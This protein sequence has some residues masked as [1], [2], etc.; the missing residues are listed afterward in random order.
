VFVITEHSE[1]LLAKSMPYKSAKDLS[2][3]QDGSDL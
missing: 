2:L 3:R 1:G